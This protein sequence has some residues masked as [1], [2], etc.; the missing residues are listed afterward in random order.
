MINDTLGLDLQSDADPKLR[1]RH[2]IDNGCSVELILYAACMFSRPDWCELA[3]QAGAHANGRD[4]LRPPWQ[5]SY[6]P[7]CEAIRAKSYECVRVLVQWGARLDIAFGLG[8]QTP[9]CEAID[10]RDYQ[11][12]E[13]LLKLGADP[14]GCGGR[15]MWITRA[16]TVSVDMAELFLDYGADACDCDSS[17]GGGEEMQRM[18]NRRSGC[19][20]AAATLYG[21]LRKRKRIPGSSSGYWMPKELV[22]QM[23]RW[24][25]ETRRETVW[26][27]L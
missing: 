16:C 8:K 7:V 26:L 1:F 2:F 23:A 10:Q 9:M 27:F 17:G 13:C 3:L 11:A 20:Q 22:T 5:M 18:L 12:V 4:Y 25:W 19:K 24:V 14:H 6:L 15:G 21:V